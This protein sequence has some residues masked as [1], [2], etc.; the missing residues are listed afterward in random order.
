MQLWIF[1][2]LL[3]F[4]QINGQL[5]KQK[6]QEYG[7]LV[8][9]SESSPT[10][11]LEASSN[12][13]SKCGIVETP[14]IVAGTKAK[15]AEFPHM[16]LIGYGSPV[17]G[18]HCGG[19]IISET[20][21]LSA[22]HCISHPTDGAASVVRV[23]IV[24]RD[25]TGGMQELKISKIIAHPDYKS[26]IKYHDIALFK[27]ASKIAFNAN[28]RPACLNTDPN[29]AWEK[30][31]VIGFGQVSSDG[32]T[33]EHLMKVS[34]SNYPRNECEKTYKDNAGMP[35][36]LLESQF[37]AGEVAGGKDSC[38]G[39]SGGAIQ[40]VLKD[41]YCMYSI[42]GVVSFGKMCA[43]A[44]SPGIYTKVA[45]YIPWIEQNAFN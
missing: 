6:C 10:L 27:L 9:E 8:Y 29:L 32:P 5:S 44:N 24:K 3:N 38:Q 43:F 39:D 1:L 30:A 22:S 40:V 31:I 35:Q 21:I 4:W 17:A 2:F 16:A 45:S 36:G 33:S 23:G 13:V 28:I 19:S 34:L 14:L 18:W 11:H 41:P 15:L 20:A 42:I 7:K 12:S 26:D 37:C 25:D